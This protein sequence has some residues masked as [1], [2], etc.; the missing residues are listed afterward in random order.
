MS[1]EKKGVPNCIKGGCYGV[2]NC[3]GCGFDKAED[4]RRKEIP[5]T[6]CEDGLR[7]KIIHRKIV[8]E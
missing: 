7:R 8:E 5:L 3:S 6:L 1:K 2:H 4:A